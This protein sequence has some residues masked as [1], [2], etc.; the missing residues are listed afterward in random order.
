MGETKIEGEKGLK[1]LQF[2][3]TP[4]MF[5]YLAAFFVGVADYVESET[6]YGVKVRVYTPVGKKEHGQFALD[7]GVKS[8]EF[9]EDY[10]NV[11]FPLPKCDQIGLDDFSAGAMENW[12]LVTYRSN[13]LLIDPAN[14]STAVKERVAIVVAHELAHQWFGNLV[15]MEWWTHLWLNEGFASFMEYLCIDAIYPEW[16]IFD[17]FIGSAFYNAI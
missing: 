2:Q 5:T 11:K 3:S 14:S 13:C 6:K 4:I 15:T 12:G 10:F 9:Y 7:M 8:L 1:K 16:E 17:E